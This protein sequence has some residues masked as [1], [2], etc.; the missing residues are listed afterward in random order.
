MNAAEK[1]KF[2]ALQDFWFSFKIE[3][4]K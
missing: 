2:Q 3:K 1:I 4:N